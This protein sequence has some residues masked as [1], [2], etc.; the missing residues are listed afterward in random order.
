LDL[1]VI[2]EAETLL[3]GV[4]EEEQK[5]RLSDE[6]RAASQ[7]IRDWIESRMAGV[8]FTVWCREH[9]RNFTPLTRIYVYD[10]PKA[11]EK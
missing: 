9:G 6:L 11:P 7:L 5:T 4:S 8:D 10:R 1:S 3:A 2:A